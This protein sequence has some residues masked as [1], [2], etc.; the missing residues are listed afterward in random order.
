M[1]PSEGEKLMKLR[2][3]TFHLWNQKKES[4]GFRKLTHSEFAEILHHSV[5]DESI[6]RIP[7]SVDTPVSQRRRRDGEHA[8]I[9][10]YM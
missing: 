2:V 6:S 7:M 1:R 5:A 3:S 10:E 4:L 9:C 8:T